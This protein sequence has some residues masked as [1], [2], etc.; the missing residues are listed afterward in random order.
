[1][2]AQYLAIK[3]DL[4]KRHLMEKDAKSRAARIYISQGKT[5]AERSER[6]KELQKG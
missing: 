6:A 1:M 4:L 5:P 3:D 2:P